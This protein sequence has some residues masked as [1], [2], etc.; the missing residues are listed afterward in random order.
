MD[1]KYCRKPII[2]NLTIVECLLPLAIYPEIC[3][4][5]QKKFQRIDENCCPYCSRQQSNKMICADCEKWAK[6]YPEYHFQHTALYQYNQGMKEWMYRFKFLGDIQLA[7]TFSQELNKEIHKQKVDI[8]CP[9]PLSN[10]RKQERG[11]NQVEEILKAAKVP[12]QLLL[13]KKD[14]LSPQ[15]EKTK[16]ERLKMSQPFELSW[17]DKMTDCSILIVDDVYTTGRT[18]LH[19][20]DCFKELTRVK[21][22]T[23]SLAR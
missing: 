10:K 2:R 9:I 6:L 16:E 19:A 11:Y 23:F 4:E 5:C 12:Y 20:I 8:V 21:I 22:K 18:M 14:D 17:T 1:C 3:V 15:S 7:S 13:S